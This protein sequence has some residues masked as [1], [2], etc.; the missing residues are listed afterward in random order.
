MKEGTDVTVYNFNLLVG[1]VSTGVDYAQAYR[2][3]ILRDVC[4]QKYVFTE[5]PR[6]RELEYYTRL[7]IR[8]DELLVL[9]FS[10][11]KTPN[12]MPSLTFP[13]VRGRI[14][15]DTEG[16]RVT[17]EKNT[18]TFNHTENGQ[19]IIFRMTDEGY[20]HSVEYY[21]NS[22]LL[23]KDSYS[24]RLLTSQFMMVSRK[25][26]EKTVVP[27]SRRIYDEDGNTAVEMFY[28]SDGII[29]ELPDHSRYNTQ[30][31]LER[32]LKERTF[33][34][35]DV[36]ILDRKDPH[37][38]VL[39]ENKGDAKIVF[40]MHSRLVFEDYSDS[41]HWKGVSYEY[42][43]LVRN[44]ERIDA[45]ITST[46]E[47]A[48]SI[49]EWFGRQY[50]MNVRVSVVPVGG[51]EKL[52]FP[53][54]PRKRHSLVSVS[55][56]DHRKR[57]D[58]LIQAVAKARKTI[59]DLTLDIYGEGPK[60]GQYADLIEEYGAGDYI[61]LKGYVQNFDGY[62]EYE[63]YISASL[64]ETFG[65]T[66]LEAMS[67][68]LP[69]IGLDVP[70]GNRSFICTGKN[71]FLVPFDKTWEDSVTVEHLSEAVMNLFSEDLEI[72]SLNS[73]GVAAKYT[74]D[75]IREQWISLFREIGVN[76]SDCFAG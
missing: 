11:M 12:L 42:T 31:L 36:F 3:R 24:D 74:T 35:D 7:G 29:Y 57:I 71:G 60:R 8:A 75:F 20:V 68:G 54:R 17:E 13:E 25:E 40:V 51:M 28:T 44:A 66:I 67:A 27:V 56:L 69:V 1:Y 43:D 55:R 62:P 5:I 65:L 2:A 76:I 32:F 21:V 41:H 72:F 18:R 61:T 45:L 26:N 48:E 6:F 53:T 47:Q 10:F 33:D 38:M 4:A 52:T 37:L 22:I 9:P 39:L 30:E 14:L 19:G 23:R 49:R 58:L 50:G 64:W 15:P 70:Y 59:P 16:F 73:Y 34:S 46:E 63:G